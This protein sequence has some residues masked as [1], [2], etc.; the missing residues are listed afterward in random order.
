MENVKRSTLIISLVVVS[1]LIVGGTFF[2]SGEKGGLQGSM[3]RSSNIRTT[4]VATLGKPIIL[5]PESNAVLT[6]FPRIAF[7]SWAS[8]PGADSYEI[9]V[10]CDICGIGDDGRPY[11]LS[12]TYTSATNTFRTPELAG[13]NTFRVKVRAINASSR[14]SWSEYIYFTYKTPFIE[15]PR[16]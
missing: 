16:Y 8:I 12:D 11:S 9:S 1:A 13:N 6:N 3:D 5:S 14:S 7:L 2:L 15:N 4:P 10:S